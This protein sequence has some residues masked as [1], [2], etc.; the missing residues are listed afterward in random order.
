MLEQI[1]SIVYW[2]QHFNW[3]MLGAESAI[4]AVK[5]ARENI[6]LTNGLKD[7]IEIR[8]Q[9]NKSF[10]FKNIIQQKEQFVLSVCN[11]PFHSSKAMAIKGSLKKTK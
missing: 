1:V 8:H 9:E 3:S 7:K 11:P 6:Q 4:A 5:N 10:L 2:A